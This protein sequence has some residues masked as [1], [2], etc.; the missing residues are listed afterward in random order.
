M[1]TLLEPA[2]TT[3]MYIELGKKKKRKRYPLK[4]SMLQELSQDS[5]WQAA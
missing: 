1:A 3:L 5:F 2:M 4:L